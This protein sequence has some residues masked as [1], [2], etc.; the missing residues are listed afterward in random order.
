MP[1]EKHYI[2]CYNFT[3]DLWEVNFMLNNQEE[4]IMKMKALNGTIL[5]FENRVVIQRKN[6]TAIATQGL[7]GDTTF[8]YNSLSGI[9]YKKPGLINGYIRFVTAGTSVH[10]PK[11]GIFT[12]PKSTMEDPNTVILSAINSSVPAVSEQI[13]AFIST[14]VHETKCTTSQNIGTSGADE[15][16]KYKA[17]YDQGVISLED[18]ERKKNQI[19]NM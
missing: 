4:P 11:F 10:N 2:L 16:A 9:E 18:F 5:V 15:I 6:L 14:K 7:K 13:Y 3:K 17:L 8:F 12:T 1:I 19:L